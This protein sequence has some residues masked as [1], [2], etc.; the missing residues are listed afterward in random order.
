MKEIKIYEIPN[1]DFVERIDDPY[2]GMIFYVADIDTY[3]SV[4]TLKEINGINMK[5]SKVVEYV[6]D[7]YADFGTGSGGGSGLTDAQLSNIAKIPAIQSTVDALPNNYAS[8]NHNHSEYASSSHRHDASEIDNLPSGGGTGLTT[9]QANNIAKIPNIENSLKNID[10]I[11]VNGKKISGPMTKAEFEALTTKED[12]TIYLIDDDIAIE[13]LPSYSINEAN[14]ILAVSSDGTTL[15]WVDKP[16]G[17]SGTSVTVIDNLTSTSTTEALSANQ[18]RNLKGQLDSLSLASGTTLQYAGKKMECFG[19]SITA[20]GVYQELIKSKLG[21]SEVLNHGIGGTC[22]SGTGENAFWQDVRINALDTTAD[23]VLLT[24]GSNDWQQNLT[25]GD[26]NSTGTNTFY[27]A[28]KYVIEKLITLYP[29]K[30]FIVATP[31]W[32]KSDAS[33]INASGKNQQGYGIGDYA[34]ALKECAE[35]YCIPVADVYHDCGFN[36][37]NKDYYFGDKDGTKKG[38]YLHPNTAYGHPKIANCICAKLKTLDVVG[39]GSETYGGLVVSDTQFDVNEGDTNIS[40]TVALD[41]APSGNQSVSISSDNSDITLSNSSLVFNSTNY[42]VAQTITFNIAE[43]ADT[44]DETAVITI[45]TLGS[46]VTITVNITDNDVTEDVINPGDNLITSNSK[47]VYRSGRT[48]SGASITNGDFVMTLD[49]GNMAAIVVPITQ[50]KQ[51]IISYETKTGIHAKYQP[52]YNFY[53]AEPTYV[54]QDEETL[55]STTGFIGTQTTQTVTAPDTATYMGF[56][57]Y[58]NTSGEGAYTGVSI[59]EVV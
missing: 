13:G 15:A 10:A 16:S 31:I 26:I 11:S 14:K 22:I 25:M 52:M 2:I 53:S 44:T 18:G 19:D 33:T 46:S 34:K 28:C 54:Q 39:T 56:A 55:I 41:T 12:N 35:L 59:K 30:L 1:I 50:G 24:G 36:D 48:Q 3:Y 6:I 5:G 42:N 58:A 49:S 7:D 23:V 4:K 57:C 17:G 8:K 47:I 45:S 51:Y 9:E 37:I 29:N 21:F 43:D 38:D 27:G 40:F 32:G 20:R